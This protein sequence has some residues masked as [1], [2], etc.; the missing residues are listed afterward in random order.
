VAEQRLTHP[1][2]VLYPECNVTKKKLFD[3]YARVG[4]WMVPH[5]SLRP[6]NLKRCPSGWKRGFFQQHVQTKAP[7]LRKIEIVD[8]SGDSN[9]VVLDDG[10]GLLSL[11]QMNVLEIHTWGAHEDE[12]EKPDLIVFDLDPDP[13]VKWPA[14]V[15]AARTIRQRL[16]DAKMESYVKTTG[17]KGLHICVA[18]ERTA[19][20]DRAREF[21]HD[22]TM[23]M[24]EEAP[25]KYIATASKAKRKGKVFIDWLRNGRGATFVA[26]YSTR[27]RANAP[28][29]LPVE[30]DELDKIKP[31]QFSLDQTIERLEKRGDAWAKMLAKPQRMPAK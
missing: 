30:W 9:R 2:K 16:G 14:I 13:D 10:S 31:N 25:E 11:A 17:G 20:W 1:E 21:C 6:L 26:P 3:Y 12:L 19:T 27:A 7:G 29:A 4:K 24:V 22:L 15:E 5:V 23:G 18:F 28:V 8:G